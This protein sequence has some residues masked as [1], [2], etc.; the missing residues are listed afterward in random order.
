MK[1]D[2]PISGELL[3][4]TLVTNLNHQEMSVDL[5]RVS[6]PTCGLLV[7]PDIRFCPN[8]STPIHKNESSHSIPNYEFIQLLGSG[9]MGHVYE[10]EHVVLKNR[11]AIK[12]LKPNLVETSAFMRFQQE[13]RATSQLKHPN[14]VWVYDCGLSQLGEPYMIMDLI[15]G[16]TLDALLKDGPLTVTESLAIVRQICQGMSRAHDRGILHRDLKPSNVMLE[17]QGVTRVAR[18]LDFGI[19]KILQDNEVGS[20]NTRTGEIFGTPAYMSPEQIAG[21][22]LDQRSDVYAVGCILYELL[23]GQPPVIGKS[24]M[25]IMYKRMNEVP[26]PLSQASLGKKFPADLDKIV[27]RSLAKQPSDRF[28]TMEVMVA[29]ID[30][31][32]AGRAQEFDQSASALTPKKQTIRTNNKI[33][34][35]GGFTLFAILVVGAIAIVMKTDEPDKSQVHIQRQSDLGSSSAATGME[36]LENGDNARFLKKLHDNTMIS[37]IKDVPIQITDSAL[38]QVDKFVH[39]ETVNLSECTNIT[40]AGLTPLVRLPKLI[41][42]H[43]P[44]TK[45]G[46]ECIPIINKMSRLDDL[47]LSGSRLTDLGLNNLSASLPLTRLRLL[48]LPITNEAVQRLSR[49]KHLRHLRLDH[50]PNITVKALSKLAGSEMMDLSLGYTNITSDVY[51]P[52]LAMPELT[53]IYLNDTNIDDHVLDALLPV[54]QLKYLNVTHCPGITAGAVTRFKEHHPHCR[55]ISDLDKAPQKSLL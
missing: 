41:T 11:V 20:N 30:N 5:V 18:I 14:I 7:P 21:Q 28:A 49:F 38:V 39:V 4:D 44:N 23:T 8:D 29:A 6:C 10:A 13:A 36:L 3:S 46:D 31:F 52:I 35:F 27:S 25:E 22:K 15:K 43:L 34:L 51:K 37:N 33:A 12:I 53:D 2:T 9:G 50:C 48:N 26:L 32:T 40:A 17:N 55:I 24:A 47:D 45:L 42:L 1:N 16:Q 19:A 54:K